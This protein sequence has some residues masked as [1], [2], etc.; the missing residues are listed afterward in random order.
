MKLTSIELGPTPAEEECAQVGDH[1]YADRSRTECEAFRAQILRH[2]PVPEGLGQQAGLRIVSNPHEF[3][4]YREV[5]VAYDP[6]SVR[7]TTWAHQVEADRIG[8]LNKWDHEARAIL[9][10]SEAVHA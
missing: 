4:S 3:G 9:G 10:I 7:A 5:E 1:N 6:F 2:Y 8:R